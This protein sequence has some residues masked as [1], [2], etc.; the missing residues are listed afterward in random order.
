MRTI[1]ALI[2]LLGFKVG[3]AR[4]EISLRPNP[5]VIGQ[6]LQLIIRQY[7][8]SISATPDFSPLR[9]DF[10]IIGHQQSVSYQSI[11]GKSQRENMWTLILMPKHGGKVT[12]PALNIGDEKTDVLTIG[13]RKSQQQPSKLVHQ[14]ESTFLEWHVS[15]ERPVVH[16][17][18]NLTL[19]IYH[20][21]PLLDAKLQA[22]T[23]KNGLLF[24]LEQALRYFE[25]KDGVRYEVEEYR[26]IIYPQKSGKLELKPP[27][28]D[29]IEYGLAPTPV[30]VGLSPKSL[31]VEPPPSGQSLAT[32]LPAQKLMFK[33]LK[34]LNAKMG[35]PV[36][37]ALVRQLQIT[38]VG[39]PA[40]LIPDLKASCGKACKVYMN[41][42][43]IS[44]KMQNG[45][46]YGRK[47][48]DIT[49]L[50]SEVGEKDIPSIH[51]PWFNT[52]T[53]NLELL[54]IPGVHVDV[55]AN[56][57][58]KSEVNKRLEANQ[59]THM[60]SWLFA[61][62]GFLGGGILMKFQ[63]KWSWKKGLRRLRGLEFEHYALKKAC[64]H[65]QAEK[66]RLEILTWAKKTG[67][68]NTIFDLHDIMSELPPGNFRDELQ[69]LMTYLFSPRQGK[70]WH[71]SRFWRAFKAFK[72]K[73]ETAHVHAQQSFKLNP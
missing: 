61:I 35:L 29:A 14:N 18:V 5:P 72:F 73:Q 51:I 27:V 38:A 66:A 36:D 58:N 63:S 8:K 21:Q 39:M 65:H 1:I 54:K 32:W 31:L 46:L 67:F 50:F 69:V 16:E 26:Y 40:Q 43:K 62:L 45:S 7:D 11:N 64:L 3:F 68:K 22:P 57:K 37:D 56:Q 42:A 23:V 15:P 41:P 30:H 17:Q 44:N 55:F 25:M 28:L 34:P 10:V 19:K 13:I 52:S 24:A 12:I 71:G 59:A 9:Q 53:R 2:L 48:Y 60:H 33:D 6:E 47:T 70:K 20:L 4:V 49:Y